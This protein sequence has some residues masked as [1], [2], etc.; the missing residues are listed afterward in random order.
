V[1]VVGSVGFDADD[2]GVGKGVSNSKCVAGH[3][4]PAADRTDEMG[5]RAFVMCQFP[6]DFEAADAVAGDDV[7]VIV[8]GG[9]NGR[10][11]FR[12]FAGHAIAVS[13]E[14]ITSDVI[15]ADLSAE[16]TG[17]VEFHP[18]CGFGHDDDDALSIAHAGEGDSRGEISGGVCGNGSISDA[19]E[20]MGHPIESTEEFEGADGGP[21]VVLDP[22]TTVF[23]ETEGFFQ[24]VGADEWSRGEV[25]PDDL[26]GL[27]DVRVVDGFEV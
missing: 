26:F 14:V 19:I 5:D 13:G 9:L 1:E 20:V 21:A 23:G 22:D 2:A 6:N 11:F 18:R 8:G 3:E 27:E 24:G 25:L 17:Q 4:S 16:G 15:C 12:D 7:G 10:F